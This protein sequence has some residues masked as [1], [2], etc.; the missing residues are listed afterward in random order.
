MRPCPPPRF[1]LFGP[2]LLLCAC[3]TDP[4]EEG[5]E[6]VSGSLSCLDTTGVPAWTFA[7]SLRGPVKS[8]GTVSFVHTDVIENPS[9]YAMTLDGQGPDG[10]LDF[11]TFVDGTLA[12]QQAQPGDVPFD[13]GVT[14]SLLLKFCATNEVD[15]SEPCWTCDDGS[16]DAPPGDSIG[17]IPCEISLP[18]E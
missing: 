14:A 15:R 9:G 18:T 5:I 12:G 2:L 10:R 13:C 17:W 8:D 16:G 11:G 3:P 1:A 7:I 4:P 6:P